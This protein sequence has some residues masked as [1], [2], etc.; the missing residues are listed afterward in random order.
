MKKERFG[1]F[2]FPQTSP[3]TNLHTMS[4]P[5]GG[6]KRSLVLFPQ[7]NIRVHKRAASVMAKKHMVLTQ[8]PNLGDCPMGGWQMGVTLCFPPPH[9]SYE[10]FTVLTV[11]SPTTSKQVDRNVMLKT[12]I[13]LPLLLPRCVLKEIPIKSV[14]QIAVD[15]TL[16]IDL[17]FTLRVYCCTLLSS[18]GS[19]FPG[20]TRPCE[21]QRSRL[22]TSCAGARTFLTST[23]SKQLIALA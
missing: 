11:S 8:G 1:E 23:F 19:E 5:R 13:F 10:E 4:P 14:P 6:K 16:S 17:S 12:R 15:T 21:S 22:V 20:T 3:A 18:E 7:L 9:L 2:F